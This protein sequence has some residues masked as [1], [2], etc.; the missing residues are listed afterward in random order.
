MSKKRMLY[1]TAFPP[2]HLSGGQTYSYNALV[3][4]SSK[5]DIDLVYFDYNGHQVEEIDRVRILSHFSPSLSGCVQMP[6]LYPV[7]T[8]RFSY[9]VLN[10]LK[11][12]C[13]QYN[14][15]YF[16]Y[17][18]TGIYSLFLKHDKKIIR[19]HDILAQKYKREG[20]KALSWVKSSE[21]KILKSANQIF[22]PSY[23]DTDVIKK[24][25]GFDSIYTNEYLPEFQI[26]NGQKVDDTFILYGL[27]SRYENFEGLEWFLKNVYDQ[28]VDLLQGK[29]YVMGG[30][31]TN[32]QK[33]EFLAPRHIKYLGYV[34]DS[35]SEI[36]RHKA[37][38]VPLLQGAGI[39]VKVL[40]SFNT[41][42]PVIGT[43]LAFE[44]IDEIDGLTYRADT[45]EDFVKY[46][47]IIKPYPDEKK[48]TLQQEFLNYYDN[49]HLTDFL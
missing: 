28:D 43:D 45:A 32:D 44:G 16:D 1:I 12:I 25:Y 49:R 33:A 35:Y 29:V 5:Y 47:E 17:I 38:I 37:M 2:N 18:Q 27:W 30:G 22:V 31:I 14:V 26:P 21:R 39:K 36:V 10:Y 11:K 3:D 46:F 42:T 34:K 4:L 15:L 8:R 48:R 9:K 20:N 19:C 13:P 40:D 6:F 24:L 41:G 23:K 7:F